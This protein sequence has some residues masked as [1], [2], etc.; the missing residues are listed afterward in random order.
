MNFRNT[1]KEDWII[2]VSIISCLFGMLI[3]PI[4][5]DYYGKEYP[6]FMFFIFGIQWLIISIKLNNK[7]N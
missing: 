5:F 3:L 1:K 2:F 6:I 7:T 4:I